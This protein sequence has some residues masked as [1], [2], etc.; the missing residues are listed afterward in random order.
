MKKLMP[1]TALAIV[2]CLSLLARAALGAPIDYTVQF[3]PG[4]FDSGDPLGLQ[5][6]QFTVEYEWDASTLVPTFD[7]PSGGATRVT[8]W[9]ST[10]LNLSL[11]I[12]GS[13]AADGTYA[14]TT[15][16]G[17]QFQL[18]D[19]GTTPPVGDSVQFPIAT[20]GLPGDTMTISGLNADF[21]T[22]FNTPA[23]PGTVY[24][25]PFGT[26]DVISWQTPY[27]DYGGNGSLGQNVSGSAAFVPEPSTL[28]LVG[29]LLGLSVWRRRPKRA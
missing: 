28:L 14:G 26:S 27:L 7:A 19:N 24:P 5:G 13:S 16:G 21:P 1:A 23:P 12:T 22:S 20:F 8:D 17:D 2:V 18:T 9:P 25:Y 29:G 10:N 4:A 11:T 3:T 15:V 6:S